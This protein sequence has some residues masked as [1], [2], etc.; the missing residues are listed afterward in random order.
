[1]SKEPGASD[2]RNSTLT[3]DDIAQKKPLR[4]GAEM[5][6]SGEEY[7]VSLGE[8]RVFALAPAAYYIW[9]LCD[10]VRS[11]EDILEKVE[12][13]LKEGGEEGLSEFELKHI[14][15]LVLSELGSVGLITWT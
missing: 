13:D 14:L 11:V 9:S 15:V 5:G 3:F 2:R 4:H 6:V 7:I 1:M 8:D 12:S 10:G